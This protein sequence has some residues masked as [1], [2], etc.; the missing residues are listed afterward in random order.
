MRIGRGTVQGR[1]ARLFG[2]LQG[3]ERA[4]K[5]GPPAGFPLRSSVVALLLLPVSIPFTS[6][7]KSIYLIARRAL[8]FQKGAEKGHRL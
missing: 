2:G 8:F 3:K 4:A 7:E 6:L 5:P 1:R